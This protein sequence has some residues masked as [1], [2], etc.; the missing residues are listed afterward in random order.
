MAL[1]QGTLS[2]RYRGEHPGRT[3]LHLFRPDRGR[4]APAVA[5]FFGKHTPV[6]AALRGGGAY[7]GLQAAQPA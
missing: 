4:V 2:H 1:P 6:R 7:P 5:A 3:L